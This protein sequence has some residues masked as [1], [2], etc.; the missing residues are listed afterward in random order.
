MFRKISDCA[1]IDYGTSD[2]L[3]IL[4]SSKPAM[5]RDAFD[6]VTFVRDMPH[7]KLYLRDAQS[8]YLYHTGID[9]LTSSIDE[10]VEFLRVFIKRMKPKQLTFMGMSGGG[11]AA[12]L[13][14]HLV[15]RDP[16]CRVD[17]VHVQSSIS[18]LDP[19]VRDRLGGGERLTGLFQN[20]ADY[21]ASKGEPHRYADLAKVIAESPG[22]VRL[23]RM[24]YAQGDVIDSLQ[25]Q[26]IAG[27][28]H[29][30]A[31]PHPSQSHMMLG[32]TVMREGT[33]YRDVDMS[34][35][36]LL[37]TNPPAEPVPDKVPAMIGMTGMMARQG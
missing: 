11:Y 21:M 36:E 15:G 5:R 24:Y 25:A 9:G 28:A 16:E 13:H 14:A 23:L 10:T 22:A 29:V 6:Y 32:G 33:L 35:D 2:R 37:Q 4:F 7:T 1:A 30:Q 18:F 26:H 8:D 31:V 34:V 27:F 19:A 3:M 20:L 12:T 17:D